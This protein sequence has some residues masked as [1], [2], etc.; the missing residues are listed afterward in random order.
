M[1]AR[2]AIAIFF[3]IVAGATLTW[4]VQIIQQAW[5]PERG[6]ANVSCRD[7]VLGLIS[8]IRRARQAAD[9]ETGGERAAV[10]RFR[11]ALD[12]E[13]RGR[14]ALD[15]ACRG[16][17]VGERGLRDVDRLRYAEEHATRYEA[18]DLA[19]RRRGIRALERRLSAH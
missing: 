6:P 3:V 5:F 12:P 8:A 1:G 16:D 10:E 11:S 18:V 19:R 9:A 15:A 17:T 7:G 2:V 13:W 14:N 4:T